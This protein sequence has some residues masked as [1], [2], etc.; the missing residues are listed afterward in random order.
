[1][2]IITLGS[3]CIKSQKNHENAVLAAKNCGIDDPV[4]NLGDLAEIQK[5]GV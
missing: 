1:M 5:Y 2:N 4:V 3:C